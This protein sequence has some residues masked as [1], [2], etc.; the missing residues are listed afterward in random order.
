MT[1]TSEVRF[2]LLMFTVRVG[3][4]YTSAA[5][6]IDND[7]SILHTATSCSSA[8]GTHP[9]THLHTHTQALKIDDE[10]DVRIELIVYRISRREPS[11]DFNLIL[12]VPPWNRLNYRTNLCIWS[13]DFQTFE[14]KKV[15]KKDRGGK[16]KSAVL[17][18]GRLT[19]LYM[20][21]IQPQR[22]YCMYRLKLRL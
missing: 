18:S 4:L 12:G 15:S 21:L 13:E 19:V 7:I 20:T 3:Q 16:N 17:H 9:H 8:P 22:L 14:L 5:S 2:Q 11:H 10:H 1:E 6:S